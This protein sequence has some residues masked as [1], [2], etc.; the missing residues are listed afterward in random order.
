MKERGQEATQILR[1][2]CRVGYLQW[3]TQAYDS[4]NIDIIGASH[5]AAYPEIVE[6]S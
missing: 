3:I 2:H 1:R 6:A 4:R 5:H